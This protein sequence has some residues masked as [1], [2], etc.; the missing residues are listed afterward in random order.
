MVRDH[1][2]CCAAD[3]AAQNIVRLERV[4]C[5]KILPSM[6]SL[7]DLAEFA[8]DREMKYDPYGEEYDSNYGA[9]FNYD[10]ERYIEAEELNQSVVRQVFYNSLIITISAYLEQSLLI[11]LGALK[12]KEVSE[13]PSQCHVWKKMLN[14]FSDLGRPLDAHA[15]FGKIES[16]RHLSNAIKHGVGTSAKVVEEQMPEILEFAHDPSR[17]G[18]SGIFNVVDRSISTPM[19]YDEIAVTKDEI[20]DYLESAKDLLLSF[21]LSECKSEL[22]K[23]I[24]ELNT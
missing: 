20:L 22:C 23:E 7:S 3:D 12:N 10:R 18:R 5:E 21:K 13:L 16:Y 6:D 8:V 17:G 2:A 24:S 14:H 11:M 15:S 4:I 1:K 9:R 19:I